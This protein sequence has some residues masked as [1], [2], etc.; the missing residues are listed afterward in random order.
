MT[1]GVLNEFLILFIK[2]ILIFRASRYEVVIQ[3]PRSVTRPEDECRIISNFN[4]LFKN[5]TNRDVSLKCTQIN[6]PDRTMTLK[7]RIIVYKVVKKCR[8]WYS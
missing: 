4:E 8:K 5:G 1:Q 3:P 6:L 2:K 7:Q